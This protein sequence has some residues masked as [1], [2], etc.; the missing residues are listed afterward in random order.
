ME[1]RVEESM[2]EMKLESWRN[3]GGIMEK[4]PCG[5]EYWQNNREGNPCES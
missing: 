2:V 5:S 4:N 1:E 3:N